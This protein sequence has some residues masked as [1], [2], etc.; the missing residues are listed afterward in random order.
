M[1]CPWVLF[2]LSCVSG[3]ED[4]GVWFWGWAKDV[5][6]LV[7]GSL[8]R[9]RVLKIVIFEIIRSDYIFSI[10]FLFC[11]VGGNMKNKCNFLQS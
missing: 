11:E 9:T 8:V 1:L 6:K 3:R 5:Q 4:T 10:A 7:L 2:H